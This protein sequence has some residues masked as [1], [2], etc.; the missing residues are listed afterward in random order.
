MKIGRLGG[1]GIALV[2]SLVA[3][4]AKQ[5]AGSSPAS[6]GQ[7]PGGVAPAVTRAQA[8]DTVYLVEHYVRPESRQQFEEFV[9]GVLWPAFQRAAATN[10]VRG[11]MLQQSRLLRPVTPNDDGTYTYTFILDPLVTGESYSVLDLLRE[12]HPEEAAK[13]HYE[14]FTE[15]WAR[16]F[17]SRPFIQR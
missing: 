11:R 7:R 3:C 17:T 14:R 8:G 4:A 13:Q 15:T 5:D 9:D 2:L 10:A 6:A 12:V 16:D 1:S